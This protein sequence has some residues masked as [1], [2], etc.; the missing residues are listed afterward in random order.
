VLLALCALAT[1]SLM[2]VPILGNKAL[3]VHVMFDLALLAYGYG[4]VRRRHLSAEREIKVRMLYP[5][6]PTAADP[7]V[8]PMRRTASG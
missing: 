2:A 6:R 8:V 7:V 5:D 1:L 3:T 4:L